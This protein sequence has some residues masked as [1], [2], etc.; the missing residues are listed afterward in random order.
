MLADSSCNETNQSSS[1]GGV[2]YRASSTQVK[3]NLSREEKKSR[4]DVY[5]LPSRTVTEPKSIFA[6][7]RS[8]ISLLGKT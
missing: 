7:S 5:T 2:T 8:N 3:L 4:V 1:Y 6:I